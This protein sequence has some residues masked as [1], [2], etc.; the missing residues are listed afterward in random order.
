MNSI[1][2]GIAGALISGVAMYT[3]GANDALGAVR[4]HAV[5]AADLR[6]CAAADRGAFGS[7]RDTSAA[8]HHAANDDQRRAASG[9]SQDAGAG[10]RGHS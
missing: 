7:R 9:V 2:A 8:E 3:L 1:A 6:H 4:R 10:A 5:G